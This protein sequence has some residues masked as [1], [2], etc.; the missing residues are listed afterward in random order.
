MIEEDQ[1]AAL[2]TLVMGNRAQFFV[3]GFL[4]AIGLINQWRA[5]QAARLK[6]L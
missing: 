6:M 5:K 4:V 3:A 2:L 1:G